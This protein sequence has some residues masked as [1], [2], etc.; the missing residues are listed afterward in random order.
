MDY[1]NLVEQLQINK[2]DNIWLSSALIK[3]VLQ[4]KKSGIKFDGSALIDVFQEAVGLDGTI[5]LPTFS[6][7]F[8]KKRKYDVLN[9]KGM[10]GAL[11]NIALGRKDFSRTRHPMHSFAVWGKDK[12]ILVGMENKHS[13]GVDSPFG[14]CIGNHVKQ[15]N[16]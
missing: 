13:F 10:T 15:V 7:E 6:F 9:T 11:G 4:F 1:M 3:M 5:M 8:S 14:Y 2:G 12:D 16:L